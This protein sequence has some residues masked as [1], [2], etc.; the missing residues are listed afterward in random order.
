[1]NSLRIKCCG[2]RRRATLPINLILLSSCPG[3]ATHKKNDAVGADYTNRISLFLSILKLVYNFTLFSS[4][5]AVTG[6]A[7]VRPQ[8]RPTPT[9]SATKG[10]TGSPSAS[11]T[12]SRRSLG[13]SP[14]SSQRSPPARRFGVPPRCPAQTTG[15]GSAARLGQNR[16]QSVRARGWSP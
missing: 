4:R 8:S 5:P 15:S 10:S 2:Q 7:V 6:G 13:A 14:A 16:S 9:V 11:T 12:P 1:M 3:T